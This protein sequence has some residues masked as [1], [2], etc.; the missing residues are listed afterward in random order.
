MRHAARRFSGLCVASR[1]KSRARAVC[2]CER[3]SVALRRSCGAS[4]SSWRRRSRRQRMRPAPADPILVRLRLHPG[5]GRSGRRRAEPGLQRQLAARAGVRVATRSGED[6]GFWGAGCG[7]AGGGHRARGGSGDPRARMGRAR[8]NE[9]DGSPLELVRRQLPYG[10]PRG[11]GGGPTR[12]G[13]THATV[14]MHR[15]FLCGQAWGGGRIAMFLRA[16]SHGV[17]A[18]ASGARPRHRSGVVGWRRDAL[19]THTHTHTRAC[20]SLGPAGFRSSSRSCFSR[21]PP[22]AKSS[23]RQAL[24]RLAEETKRARRRPRPLSGR[25]G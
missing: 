11:K 2:V 8:S 15:R 24:R 12:S 16:K 4:W 25:R 19:L 13:R 5:T 6:S 9:G 22:S 1:L 17:S 23:P 20:Y 3:E 7:W 14:S 18:L 10:V 21:G